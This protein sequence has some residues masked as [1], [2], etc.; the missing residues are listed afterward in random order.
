MSSQEGSKDKQHSS[1]PTRV[2]MLTLTLLLFNATISYA[3]V[4]YPPE[5]WKGLLRE[6]SS[7]GYHGM[8]AVACCV[9]NRMKNG[10]D[11]G[12]VG[13]KKKDLNRFVKKEGSRAE[14]IAKEAVRKVF[15]ENG[16]DITKGAIYYE[17]VEM[18]GWP[19]WTKGKKVIVTAKV[20]CHT[21]FIIVQPSKRSDSKT[22]KK[23]SSKKYAKKTKR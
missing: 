1:F 2:L 21:F 5:L 8:Y 18:Y 17:Y 4:Q 22:C 12:L 15:E 19:D 13:L 16:Y 3:E 6:A 20:G 14:I 11:H 7:E 10:K 9:R 23:A